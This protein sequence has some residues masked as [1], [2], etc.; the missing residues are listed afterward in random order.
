MILFLILTFF[1]AFSENLTITS[2]SAIQTVSNDETNLT[3]EYMLL[4]KFIIYD[5]R[6]GPDIT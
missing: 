6:G 1:I 3:I 2:L 5:F 4:F